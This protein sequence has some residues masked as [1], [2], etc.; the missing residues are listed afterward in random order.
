MLTCIWIWSVWYTALLQDMMLN[1]PNV[2]HPFC[3]TLTY[4]WIYCNWYK[5]LVEVNMRCWF[6]GIIRL[7]ELEMLV[8]LA[9]HTSKSVQRGPRTKR[10]REETCVFSIYYILY[11]RIRNGSRLL[12]FLWFT[13]TQNISSKRIST[14][15]G[16]DKHI[17]LTKFHS[18]GFRDRIKNGRD[19]AILSW[20]C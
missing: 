13:F 18:K 5:P 3:E 2:T 19:M 20:L 12:L 1:W 17:W 9:Y 6:S 11:I 16:M 14:K 4:I 7:F 10:N 15:L 8:V